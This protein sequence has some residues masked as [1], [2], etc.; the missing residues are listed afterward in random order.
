WKRYV[1]EGESWLVNLSSW[2]LL[3]TGRV[4]DMGE[5]KLALG[6]LVAR[7]GEPVIREA[8]KR[9]MKLIGGQFVLGETMAEAL[10]EARA[11]TKKGIRFSFDILGE[12]ARSDAQAQAYVAAYRDGIA[13]IAATV[14]QGTPLYDAPG[15]SVKLSA[16][17]ARY[18]LSQE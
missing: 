17:H 15:I 3:L 8:L 12:G 11:R 16:L 4:V 7:L 2:G 5:A 1:G 6:R 9:A 14:P 13:K 10:A 18:Q